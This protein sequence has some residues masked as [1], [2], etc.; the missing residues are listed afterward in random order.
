M[1]WAF[2]GGWGQE[3]SVKTVLK[4]ALLF[5]FFGDFRCGMPLFIVILVIRRSRIISFGGYIADKIYG[6]HGAPWS[7]EILIKYAF[8]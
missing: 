8:P 1:Y 5:W 3:Y 4:K 2:I 7:V 6:N